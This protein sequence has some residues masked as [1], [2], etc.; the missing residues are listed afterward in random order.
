MQNRGD[1]FAFDFK[2]VDLVDTIATNVI[3]PALIMRYLLPAIQ[4]SNRKVVLN[5]TSGLA[6]ITTDHGS[7]S[8]SYSI[9][10]AALNML[11]RLTVFGVNWFQM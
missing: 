8:A 7:R 4:K 1:D 3:G 6:S 10:K 9:S 2:P 5:M 11:V